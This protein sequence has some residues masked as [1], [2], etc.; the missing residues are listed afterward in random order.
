MRVMT[1]YRLELH[2]DSVEHSKE[3]VAV[4]KGAYFSGPV[5]QEAEQLR[6]ED[7]LILDMT[8]QHALFVPDYYQATLNWKGVE[9]KGGL[10]FLK[11]AWIRGKYVNSIAALED[12]DWI[13]IDCR[14]HE[15]AK[16]PFHLV[17]WG[18]VCKQDKEKKY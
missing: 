2:W 15:E 6:E 5:L 10:I 8:S 16:H 11:E 12:T 3:D 14:E 9:Y 4:L 7:S 17:Y 1:K 13:L 18:E